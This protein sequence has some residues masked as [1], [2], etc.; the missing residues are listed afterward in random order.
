MTRAAAFSA[1][2]VRTSSRG[3]AGLASALFFERAVD[4]LEQYGNDG[5]DSWRQTMAARLEALASA[6]E[7]G[8]EAIFTED[9]NWF[10]GIS[11]T[12]G[13][14]KADI[15]LALDCLAETVRS[16]LP[17]ETGDTVAPYFASALKR[18]QVNG[19][20]PPEFESGSDAAELFDLALMGD[21]GGSRHFLLEGIRSG[22]FDVHQVV[23]EM[24]LPAAR[25]AGRRW[26]LGQ[27]GVATEHVITATLRSALHSLTAVLPKPAPNGKAAFIA[28]VPGDAHDT[29]LIAL[30][31]LLESDGWRVALAGADTP[32]DEVDVTAEGYACDLIAL[33]ATLP[34]QRFVLSSYLSQRQS[35]I[36]VLVGG[37]AVRGEDDAKA[38]GAQGFARSLT[39]GI[40]AA[41]R[42]VGLEG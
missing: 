40:A 31:L 2:L 26:H 30:A 24:I 6:L 11:V 39:E 29:G 27:M 16:Q 19:E 25:E 12:R 33:S 18:L 34:S 3:L 20:Y 5:F 9:M 32:T 8:D 21:L 42:L 10:Q 23:S 41:R 35:S 36:P 17:E 37:A 28:A 38:I 13:I 1:E 4:A 7:A 14:P 22:R 15:L